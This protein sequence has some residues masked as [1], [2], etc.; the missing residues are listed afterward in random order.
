MAPRPKATVDTEME[1]TLNTTNKI[2]LKIKMEFK[3]FPVVDM[4][5]RDKSIKGR[6]DEALLR[7]RKK[8]PDRIHKIQNGLHAFLRIGVE[9]DSRVEGWF[10]G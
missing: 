4:E 3:T 8:N 6:I 9:V 1:K 10:S 7:L 2:K 5:D